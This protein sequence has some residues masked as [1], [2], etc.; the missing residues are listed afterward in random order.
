MKIYE[1]IIDLLDFRSV[2]VDASNITSCFMD[3]HVSSFTMDLL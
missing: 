2:G 1:A 3:G